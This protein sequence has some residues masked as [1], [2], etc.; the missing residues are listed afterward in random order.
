MEAANSGL[1]WVGFRLNVSTRMQTASGYSP[2]AAVK[3][4]L[5]PNGGWIYY[6][7]GGSPDDVIKGD[8]SSGTF[9]YLYDSK[10]HGDFHEDRVDGVVELRPP[11][12]V[13][14]VLE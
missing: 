1:G 10:Y 13:G 5:H 8:I 7:R 2:W 6:T 3:P 9:Q 11:L 4:A 12:Q 14:D